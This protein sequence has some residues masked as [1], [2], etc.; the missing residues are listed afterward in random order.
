MVAVRHGDS[1]TLNPHQSSFT[2]CEAE[3]GES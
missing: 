2:D 3:K 1:K